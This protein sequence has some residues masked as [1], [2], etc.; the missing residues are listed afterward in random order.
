[1]GNIAPASPIPPHERIPSYMTAFQSSPV[2]IWGE[3][4]Y[5]TITITMSYVTTN[6]LP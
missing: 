2:R 5:R 3:E 1:M 6:D 4:N